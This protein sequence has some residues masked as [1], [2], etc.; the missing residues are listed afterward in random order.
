M[1][2]A[3][4]TAGAPQFR[5]GVWISAND[6]CKFDPSLPVKAWPE[7]ANWTLIALNRIVHPD[8]N[9]PQKDGRLVNRSYPYV[10]AAGAPLILQESYGP[11]D[12]R[13]SYEVLDK[14]TLDDQGRIVSARLWAVGCYGPGIEEPNPYKKRT[15]P[16]ASD[17]APDNSAAPEAE[18]VVAPE[19]Q[20]PDQTDAKPPKP[21][22]GLVHLKRGG[23][24]PRNADAIRKAAIIDAP[25]ES[26]PV[27]FHWVRDGD[28]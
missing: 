12:L 13:Y 24:V 1:F 14:P 7:C 20:Q 9:A 16:A 11:W 17:P 22:P 28:Q 4:D 19:P 18:P 5:S 15:E 25:G 6:D 3:S 21:L 10:L 26:G 23:C 27:S 2:N 8:F